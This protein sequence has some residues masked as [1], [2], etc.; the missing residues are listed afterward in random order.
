M[1]NII[2]SNGLT[3]LYIDKHGVISDKFSDRSGSID[4]KVYCVGTPLYRNNAIDTVFYSIVKDYAEENLDFGKIAGNFLIVFIK[5]TSLKILSDKTQ[6]HHLFYDYQTEKVSFSFLSLVEYSRDALEINRYGVY[7]KLAL[8]FNLDEDTIFK[9]IIR[10]TPT[11][12]HNIK[13]LSIEYLSDH[14]FPELSNIGFHDN[15]L[16]KSLEDQEEV[17]SEYFSLVDETFRAQQGDLGLSGGFDCRLLLALAE[18]NLSKALHLHTHATKGVHEEQIKYAESLAECYRADLTIIETLPPSCLDEA[19]LDEML[20]ENVNFF[21]ARSARHIGAFSQ[22]YTERYKCESMGPASYSLN[23]LGG[24][25]YRDSYFA[26]KKTLS[27]DEWA[28]RYL[29]LPGSKAIFPAEELEKISMKAKRIIKKRLLWASDQYDIVFTHSY[30][31]LIKMP[32]CNGSVVSAYNKISP[33]LL[34][35]LEYRNVIEAIKAIPYLGIGG[36]YQSMLISRISPKLSELPSHY[37]GSMSSL[38][39]T[40]YS[41]ALV[42]TLFSE[43]WRS[44]ILTRRLLNKSKLQSSAKEVCF[45]SNSLPLSKAVSAI[46]AFDRRVKAKVAINENIS[47]RNIIFLGFVLA[48]YS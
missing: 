40:Y 15:G 30:Y 9:N 33:F 6:Q 18:N 38:G 10:I 4:T 36:R 46:N 48:K 12:T 41:W 21:D 25:I 13:G 11:N 44:E 31:G 14:N 42:K 35:F 7:E 17:L 29:F 22:T 24:E 16:T 43:R 1:E 28:E 39:V 2:I 19:A 27:W 26:G 20:N 32:S 5:G 37:G 23:G 45:V 34:P 8:G 47:K 3:T